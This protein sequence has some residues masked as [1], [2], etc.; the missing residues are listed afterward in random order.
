GNERRSPARLHSGGAARAQRRDQPPT[1]AST[2]D[3]MG[4]ARQRHRRS[5]REQLR[6]PVLGEDT[7]SAVGPRPPW[8]CEPN[9]C[10]ENR[11]R[12]PTRNGRRSPLRGAPRRLLASLPL[13][14]NYSPSGG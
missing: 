5:P 10:N 4:V 1:A 3:S 9:R 14:A 13:G 2:G 11:P 7:V 12:G 8:P 6:Q